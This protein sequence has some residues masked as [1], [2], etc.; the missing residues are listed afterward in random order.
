MKQISIKLQRSPTN[1]IQR[2][3]ERAYREPKSFKI[4]TQTESGIYNLEIISSIR[5]IKAYSFQLHPFTR[6][7]NQR[8]QL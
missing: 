5:P 1:L 6:A 7:K 3:K 4:H 2:F 8:D